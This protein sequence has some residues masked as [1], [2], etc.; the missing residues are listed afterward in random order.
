MDTFYTNFKAL[1]EE[2]KKNKLD[3]I[4]GFLRQ[5]NAHDQAT[6]FQELKNC[7]PKFPFSVNERVFREYLAWSEISKHQG[8]PVVKHILAQG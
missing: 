2:Q 6:A 5:N 3:Q 1:P 4:L 8:H 7:Y